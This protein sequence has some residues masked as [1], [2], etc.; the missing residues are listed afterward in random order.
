MIGFDRVTRKCSFSQLPSELAQAIREYFQA[1]QLADPEDVTS[2]C[3]ETIS[4]KRNSSKLASLLDGNPDTTIHL[5]ALLTPEWLIWARLGDR[6]GIVVSGARLKVI[7]V[8]AFV[9]R[10]T[11]NM[12]LEVSG[13]IND[14]KEYVRGNLEFGSQEAAQRFC[15]EVG[16]AAL[17][18]NPPAKRKFFGQIGN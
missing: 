14:S 4:E 15:E 5:A 12:G 6:S 3:C 1:R 13:F 18:A 16:Q 10:R 17:K 8:K 2:L 11:K 7:R 9:S